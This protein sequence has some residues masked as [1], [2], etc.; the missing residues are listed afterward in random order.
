EGFGGGVTLPGFND[1][2]IVMS[3]A[4]AGLACDSPIMIE[5]AESVNK[6]WPEFFDVYKSCGGAA[7]VIQ[8]W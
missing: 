8:H 5:D 7:N 1:H 4:V 3:M 6:S 2:R